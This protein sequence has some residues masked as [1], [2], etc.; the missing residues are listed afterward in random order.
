MTLL[1]EAEQFSVFTGFCV[2]Q[3]LVWMKSEWV[4]A[5][6]D[7]NH[8]KSIQRFV[9][10]FWL[11]ISCGCGG[12]NGLRISSTV[13]GSLFK[14][15]GW[16]HLYR[17]DKGNGHSSLRCQEQ[18]DHNDRPVPCAAP[19]CS[20]KK[21]DKTSFCHGSWWNETAFISYPGENLWPFVSCGKAG[22]AFQRLSADYDLLL[23]NA[24]RMKPGTL[25]LLQGQMFAKV[26]ASFDSSHFLE[27][28]EDQSVLSAFLVSH[29]SFNKAEN[30]LKFLKR[31]ILWRKVNGI[32][33]LASF[34]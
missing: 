17:C 18:T 25:E 20:Q 32:W 11:S 16:T 1:F 9:P 31:K 29:H 5:W 28:N 3:W 30:L 19:A 24:N 12:T 15:K 14:W 22:V 10:K 23:V 7:V 27:T 26:P 8:K 6:F 4:L 21:A 33:K 13:L 34:H 2:S